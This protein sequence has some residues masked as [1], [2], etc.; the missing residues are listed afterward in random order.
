M[1]A[2]QA[3][4]R[5]R[6]LTERHI[7]LLPTHFGELSRERQPGGPCRV[8]N[9]SQHMPLPV[10]RQDDAVGPAL[11]GMKRE[12][13]SDH[14]ELRSSRWSANLWSANSGYGSW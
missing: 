2:L 12:S 5:P 11:K 10:A 1:R 7:P 13:W 8:G 14:Y 9:T 6:R 3:A 4:V